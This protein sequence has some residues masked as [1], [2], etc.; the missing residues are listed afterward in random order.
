MLGGLF[1]IKMLKLL[2][3]AAIQPFAGLLALLRTAIIL[4]FDSLAI[5]Q[6]CILR[7]TTTGL[8]PMNH[9]II[10]ILADFFFAR[11]AHMVRTISH[12]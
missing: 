6:G 7:D 9:N 4:P 11:A 5:A 12:T 3:V 2:Q 8:A 10:A 1:A